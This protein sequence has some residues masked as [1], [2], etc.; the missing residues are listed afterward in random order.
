MITENFYKFKITEDCCSSLYRLLCCLEDNNIKFQ[1]DDKKEDSIILRPLEF[2][3]NY[4]IISKFLGNEIELL[5]R[6]GTSLK[7]KA[8][9][10]DQNNYICFYDQYFIDPFTGEWYD[11]NEKDFGTFTNALVNYSKCGI[12]KS[13]IKLSNAMR[14]VIN[15]GLLQKNIINLQL[16]NKSVE[17]YYPELKYSV[18]KIKFTGKNPKSDFEEFITDP[19][20]SRCIPWSENEEYGIWIWPERFFRDQMKNYPQ[21][22]LILNDTKNY[23]LNISREKLSGNSYILKSDDINL[24]YYCSDPK[25][26]QYLSTEDYNDETVSNCF[27]SYDK[28]LLCNEKRKR[29]I[30]TFLELVRDYGFI[31]P[32]K[33]KRVTLEE[34]GWGN[35]I[36]MPS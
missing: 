11:K 36:E 20:Y 21:G 27:L 33:T 19:T 13:Y 5:Y 29:D 31:S 4:K 35:I 3:E 7:K 1:I 25:I 15:Y 10:L 24:F 22:E 18:F 28:Y 6:N 12:R 26:N 2:I 14:E 8:L 32:D 17:K 23:K 16:R 34:Y 30:E 9:E